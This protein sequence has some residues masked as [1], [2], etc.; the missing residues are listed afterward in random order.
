MA[1]ST[2]K[3]LQGS[4]GMLRTCRFVSDIKHSF[5]NPVASSFCA[6]MGVTTLHN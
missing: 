3:Y 2:G 1:S 4:D 6:I 5:S